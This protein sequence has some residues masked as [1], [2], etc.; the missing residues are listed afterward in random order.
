MKNIDDNVENV[1]EH[2][3]SIKENLEN[4]KKMKALSL[5]QVKNKYIGKEG[6]EKREKYE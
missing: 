4:S 2:Y 5:S 6:S 1:I 3:N